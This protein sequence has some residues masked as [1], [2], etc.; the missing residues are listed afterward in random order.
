MREMYI[1]IDHEKVV[2][3]PGLRGEIASPSKNV[4]LDVQG[5]A[6]HEAF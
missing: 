4:G 3:V 5:G 6:L 1:K 2:N